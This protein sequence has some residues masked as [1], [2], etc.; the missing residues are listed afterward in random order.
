MNFISL[1]TMTEAV[2]RE[3]IVK[4]AGYAWETIGPLVHA[5][6]QTDSVGQKAFVFETSND[7]T[8]HPHYTRARLSDRYQL[9]AV[10]DGP[11]LSYEAEETV[12]G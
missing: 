3:L 11:L 9:Q 1:T 10:E 6:D 2:A 4:K 8:Q 7:V 5:A 12:G